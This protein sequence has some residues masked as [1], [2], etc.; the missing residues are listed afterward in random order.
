MIQMR[1]PN[2][3]VGSQSGTRFSRFLACISKKKEKRKISLL[4]LVTTSRG[5]YDAKRRPGM[6]DEAQERVEQSVDDNDDDDAIEIDNK[7]H[8][9]R[10]DTSYATILLFPMMRRLRWTI[11]VTSMS[12][13]S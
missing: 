7:E 12:W 11:I 13:L 8:L 3:A 5:K 2:K 1:L 6:H 4:R 10:A 9:L